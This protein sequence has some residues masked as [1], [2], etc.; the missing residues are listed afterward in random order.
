MCHP[1]GGDA[2]SVSPAPNHLTLT[3]LL[4]SD[5]SPHL[6]LSRATARFRSSDATPK[7]MPISILQRSLLFAEKA[8]QKITRLAGGAVRAWKPAKSKT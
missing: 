7:N 5:I 8:G 4:P 1:N 3:W 2:R 6:A